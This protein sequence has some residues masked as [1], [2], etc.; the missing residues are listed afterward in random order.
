MPYPFTQTQI[1][2]W[3]DR[4]SEARLFNFSGYFPPMWLLTPLERRKRRYID[5]MIPTQPGEPP[6]LCALYATEPDDVAGYM[7][8]LAAAINAELSG[9]LVEYDDTNTI[10][11]NLNA[12]H[13][14]VNAEC[15]T[16]DE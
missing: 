11:D 7:K 6:T 12:W 14:T 2:N 13:L 4:E 3:T 1:L 8:D 16:E 9:W 10:R 5:P 15:G